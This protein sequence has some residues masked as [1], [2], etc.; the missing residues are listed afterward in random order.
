[1]V[2]GTCSLYGLQVYMFWMITKPRIGHFVLR[3]ET[4]YILYQMDFQRTEKNWPF[5]GAEK[6]RY[7]HLFQCNVASRYQHNIYLVI[8]IVVIIQ[9]TAFP[10]FFFFFIK[11]EW[12]NEIAENHRAKYLWGFSWVFFFDEAENSFEKCHCWFN[13]HSIYVGIVQIWLN[14]WGRK[15]AQKSVNSRHDHTIWYMFIPCP[16][17]LCLMMMPHM[18]SPTT[19]L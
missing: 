15:M 9:C 12:R 19:E 8:H 16:M 6:K 18:K 7:R 13:S 1:M 10:F 5:G 14:Q 17:A 2:L 4:L 11:V 3:F